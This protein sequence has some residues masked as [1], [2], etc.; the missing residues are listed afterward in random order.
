MNPDL[1]EY[2]VRVELPEDAAGKLKPAMRATGEVTIGRVENTLAVPVQAVFTE[3]ED[4]FC[5]V[6]TMGG[7]VKKIPVSIGRANE[8]FAEVTKGLSEGDR[9]LLRRPRPGEQAG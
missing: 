5:Y 2:A 8:S 9:V 6:P 4:R 1:R 3:G 7:H